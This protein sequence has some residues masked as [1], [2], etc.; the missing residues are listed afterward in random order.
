MLIV[1]VT[2]AVCGCCISV[3]MTCGIGHSR[4]WHS[5]DQHTN[6]IRVT[7]FSNNL[8]LAASVLISGNCFSKSSQ[9]FDV[10]HLGCIT[11]AM[12]YRCL[13]V[14]LFLMNLVH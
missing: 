13:Q 12:F 5:S 4:T 7:I 8:P 14:Y 10:C 1:K 6:S 2:T 3:T 9:M 11:Q